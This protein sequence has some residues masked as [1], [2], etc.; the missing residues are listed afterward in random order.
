MSI[1]NIGVYIFQ[2][3]IKLYLYKLY[4]QTFTKKL[5]CMCCGNFAYHCVYTTERLPRHVPQ[6]LR[7][8]KVPAKAHS[9]SKARGIPRVIYM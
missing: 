4:I 9:L 6:Q 7:H 8:R 2:S 1:S 3:N 5:V